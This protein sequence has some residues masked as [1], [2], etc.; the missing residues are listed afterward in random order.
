MKPMLSIE[1]VL[2][3]E[4]SFNMSISFH[5]RDFKVAEQ[6]RGGNVAVDNRKVSGVRYFVWFLLEKGRPDRLKFY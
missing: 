5:S 3:P 2:N 1:L 4:Y 6:G